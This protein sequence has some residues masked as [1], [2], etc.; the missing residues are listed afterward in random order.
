MTAAVSRC[1]MIGS[2]LRIVI[3]VL[4]PLAAGCTYNPATGRSQLLLLSMEESI[5]L[6]DESKGAVVAE[7]GG[8]MPSPELRSYV[9][10]V[11]RSLADG[12]EENYV[13]LPWEFT[14][15]DTDV[16][17]AFALPGGKIFATRG[18]LEKL[19]NEAEMAGVLGHEIGHVTAQHVNERISQGLIVSGITLGATAAASQSD[20]DWVAV[21]VP[22]IVGAAGSGYMLSFSRSQEKE[23]D[24][25]GVKYMAAAGYDPHGMLEV[26]N[27]LAEVSAGPRPPEF[28]STHPYPET[29]METVRKLLAGEYKYTQNN[30]AFGKFRQRYEREALPY[31]MRP[32]DTDQASAATAGAHVWWCGV[33]RATH[34]AGR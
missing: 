24:E 1:R 20:D 17:N 28:L 19:D 32:Q 5:Q 27:V 13:E 4:L 6:G 21:G 12:V 3:V 10:L 26:L 15:L 7:Y 34:R 33:C 8:E 31:L 30:Q 16:V 14:V 2:L 9:D 18:L 22:L 11:G 23:A 29:R 25:Q